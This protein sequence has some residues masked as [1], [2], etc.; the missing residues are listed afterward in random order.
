MSFKVDIKGDYALFTRPEFK[1]ER[2]SYEVITPSAARGVLESI[3]WKP[4]IRYVIDKIYVYNKPEYI[5]IKRQEIGTKITTSGAYAIMKGK[6]QNR[7]LSIMAEDWKQMRSS[8]ILKNVHYAIEFHFE[9]TGIKSEDDG[10]TPE[11]KYYNIIKRRLKNGQCY[12]QPY[13]GCREFPATCELIEDN[14][15]PSELKGYYDLGYM[16]YDMDYRD[17]KNIKPMFFKAEMNDGVIDLTNVEILS[18]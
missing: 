4:A 15:P 14:I 10:E 1:V 8:K 17:R 5:N 16:L 9:L 18:N 3:F 7:D 6:S 13:F 11:K 2:V 12:Q